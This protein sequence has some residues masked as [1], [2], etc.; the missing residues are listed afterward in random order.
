M[1]PKLHEFAVTLQRDGPDTPWGIRLVGGSDLDTPLIITK[2]QL[3]SPAYG[4]VL[5]GDIVTKIGEYDSRDIS[6]HDAQMLFRTAG[7]EIRIVVSRDSKIAYTQGISDDS[8]CSSTVPPLS[9]VN[10]GNTPHRGPS[11]FLPGPGQYDRAMHS[12]VNT[13]PHTVFPNLNESGG[14][15][16]P[17]RPDSA[18]SQRFSPMPTRDHQQDVKEEQAAIVNQAA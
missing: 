17:Y 8:R 13:L 4:E 3:G 16:A 10:T 6:H 1:S 11:P 9:P 7:N 18:A 12:P 5:R 15:V 14:Y 2:V